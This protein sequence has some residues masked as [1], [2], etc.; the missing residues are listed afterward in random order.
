M[1]IIKCLTVITYAKC[2]YSKQPLM[3]SE[4]PQ[5]LTD[6]IDVYYTS[7]KVELEGN[8]KSKKHKDASLKY[9]FCCLSISPSYF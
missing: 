2:I 6:Y 3:L 8:R 9:V 1:I 7:M 5:T 4:K